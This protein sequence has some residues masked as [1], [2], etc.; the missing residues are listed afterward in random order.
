MEAL[1]TDIHLNCIY[2]FD[3]YLSENSARLN[4]INLSIAI[5]KGDSRCFPENHTHTHT[6]TRRKYTLKNA[7]LIYDSSGGTYNYHWA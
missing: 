4:Y 2:R 3:S 6:H 1:K 7:E 5:V